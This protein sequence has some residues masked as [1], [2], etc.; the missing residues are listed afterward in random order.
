[1]CA[2]ALTLENIRPHIPDAFYQPLLGVFDTQPQL[3]QNLSNEEGISVIIE[4]KS[5]NVRMEWHQTKKGVINGI[6]LRIYTKTYLEAYVISNKFEHR[7]I[8]VIDHHTEVRANQII[9]E[10]AAQ[11]LF[12]KCT[13]EAHANPIHFNVQHLQHPEQV[14][15]FFKKHPGT[16]PEPLRGQLFPK[17]V[18]PKPQE[19]PEEPESSRCYLYV[20]GAL[21]LTLG[22][23]FVVKKYF[24]Q[25]DPIKSI[26]LPK[27]LGGAAK[28]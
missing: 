16:L 8:V 25:Y 28:A 13:G 21:L 6:F 12:E 5:S 3:L 27:V 11:K 19:K 1:M 17:P 24:P 26:E 4:G 10:Q 20:G 15:D 22:A 14:Q 18:S 9:H 7:E 2:Q 23:L